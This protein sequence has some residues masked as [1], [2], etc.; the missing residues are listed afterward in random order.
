MVKRA[1]QVLCKA[2]KEPEQSIKIDELQ[3]VNHEIIMF[4]SL[5]KASG[6]KVK[7]FFEITGLEYKEQKGDEVDSEDRQKMLKLSQRNYD[8]VEPTV[9]ASLE[10]LFNNSDR[11]K[12]NSFV[13]LKQVAATGK[14]ELLAFLRIEDRGPDQ[15]YVG[16]FN[17]HTEAQG[18]GIGERMLAQT[19]ADL[20]KTKN[21]TAIM[22]QELAAGSL[23][24]EQVGAVATGYERYPVSDRGP[25]GHFEILVEKTKQPS[26]LAGIS[27]TELIRQYEQIA[28]GVD[29]LARIGEPVIL[30]VFDTTTEKQKIA[31]VSEELLNRQG[32][33]LTRYLNLD[34]AGI[35]RLYGFEKINTAPAAT[36]SRT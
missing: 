7:N 26:Q 9:P 36:G 33:R 3:R 32:Y 18:A 16:S 35:Q 19:I 29:P 17:V 1:N 22:N 21:V 13:V 14:L 34:A 25:V 6:P 31:D 15:V 11:L 5:L 2:V 27:R 10:E 28:K 4:A 12:Q 20:V 30:A 8:K 24:I 23:Y